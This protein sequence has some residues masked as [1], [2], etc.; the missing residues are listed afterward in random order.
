MIEF[1]PSKP[2]LYIV[3]ESH[4]NNL[5]VSNIHKH[6]RVIV[7]Y[8]LVNTSSSMELSLH[9]LCKYSQSNRFLDYPLKFNNNKNTIIII[10]CIYI[11]DSLFFVLPNILEENIPQSTRNATLRLLQ[12][13]IPTSRASTFRSNTTT[14]RHSADNTHTLHICDV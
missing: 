1:Q 14:P 3:S 9:T 11:Y 13:I 10:I 4:N 5:N 7:I 2:L 6:I 12:F 8:Q